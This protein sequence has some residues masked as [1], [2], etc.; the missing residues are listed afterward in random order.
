MHQLGIVIPYVFPTLYSSL[1]DMESLVCTTVTNP[2]NER[3][4]VLLIASFKINVSIRML[5]RSES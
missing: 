5:E 4:S 1:D 3:G 2:G